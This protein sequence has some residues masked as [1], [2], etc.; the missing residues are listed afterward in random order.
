MCEEDKNVKM[1]ADRTR[2][3]LSLNTITSTLS[4]LKNS[5]AKI[6]DLTVSNP[7]Q[8]G[9]FYPDKEILNALNKRE[10]LIYQPS[11]KGL[12]EA[13]EAVCAYYSQ[14]GVDISPEKV[15]LTSSTS[16]AYSFLF[17]LL[18]NPKD[19]IL[20]P[21]PSYP[22]FDFLGGINDVNISF[23]P[24]EYK[25]KWRLARQRFASLLTGSRA[26]VIVSPNNPTGSFF[27]QQDMDFVNAECA[28]SNIPI[29]CDEVFGDYIFDEQSAFPTFAGNKQVLTFTLGGLSK[30][31]GL[32]QMKLSWIIVS[33][34]DG[35]VKDALARLEVIADTFLSVN[36]ASQNALADWFRLRGCLQEQI[37]DRVRKNY[38]TL[39][40]L[41]NENSCCKCLNSDGGWYAVVKIGSPSDNFDEEEFVLDLLQKQGVFVH[42]G[43][44]FDF[45]ES[46]YIVL[47]LLPP[48]KVMEHGVTGLMSQINQVK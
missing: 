14:K 4:R 24:L 15:L 31:L 37:L 42:P 23:Y 13:R 19:K 38:A 5:D 36:A 11:A 29:I 33:G 6:T 12:L 26:V 41:C 18:A 48:E 9:F 10:N 16:E 47:S 39:M 21:R 45:D 8:A 28:H 35:Q 2:W 27:S 25:S 20:F 46:G 34:D 1:F 3:D 32:P 30:A 40:R 44:F 7:T 22:L 17:R 43:Y